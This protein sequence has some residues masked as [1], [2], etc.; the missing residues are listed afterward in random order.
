MAKA[1]PLKQLDAG[2]MPAGPTKHIKYMN[3]ERLYELMRTADY[4]AP[5]LAARAHILADLIAAEYQKYNDL[6]ADHVSTLVVYQPCDCGCPM[7][8]SPATSRDVKLMRVASA[9]RIG[10]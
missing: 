10:P 7:Q 5:E 1:L 9:L 3:K 8:R 2:S 4:A 6:L